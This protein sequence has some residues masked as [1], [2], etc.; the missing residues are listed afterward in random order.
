MTAPLIAWAAVAPDGTINAGTVRTRRGEA[1]FALEYWISTN[2][3][4]AYRA[5]WRVVP[6]EIRAKEDGK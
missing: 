2:R 1:W 3:R 5:G 4:S 6:V